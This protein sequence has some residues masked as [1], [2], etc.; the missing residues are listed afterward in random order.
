MRSV[1]DRYL[2]REISL[3]L[4]AAA[5]VL[6]L[7]IFGNL[8][9]RLLA[10]A[11]EAQIP[12]DVILPLLVLGGIESLILLMP[13]SLLL[14]VML[15]MGRL[16]R[17]NEMSALRACGVGYKRLYR[18]VMLVA[19][20]LAMGLAVLALYVSPWTARLAD[21]ITATLGSE[22]RLTGIMPGRFIETGDENLVFF[23]ERIDADRGLI[24]N[25]FIHA[26]ER[27][28]TVIET[29]AR[30]T[31]RIEPRTGARIVELRNGHRYEG[32]PGRGDF[33]ILSF[34]THTVRIPAKRPALAPDP[35][36]DSLPSAA[37]WR[38]AQPAAAAE[39]QWRLSV[40][41]S[42]ILL[43]LLAVPLSY[44][45]PR[46]GRYGKLALGITIYIIYANLGLIAVNWVER[47]VLPPWLGIWWVHG[48]L[49]A[50]T[51]LLFLRQY[52]LRWSMRRLLS[53]S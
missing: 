42:V 6:V 48:L 43:A 30:A 44:T 9:V 13:V 40:P 47:G 28:R 12:P 26:L 10:Q 2:V 25:V 27:G 16:Y 24:E 35:G 17:D 50:L 34:A 1:L 22:A 23:V 49:L 32:R 46:R 20:P 3:T 51:A 29:A 53:R 21:Q 5:S 45:T 4:F 39:L 52:G 11:T 33:R 7:V 8:F 31:Q 38:S 19:A 18:P 37:L 14:A 41:V 15:T 36:R